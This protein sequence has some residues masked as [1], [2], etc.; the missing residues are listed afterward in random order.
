MSLLACPKLEK[1]Q[2]SIPRLVGEI[3]PLTS[4]IG[5]VFR[6]FLLSLRTY[7]RGVPRGSA[8][9]DK[10]VVNRSLKGG[11]PFRNEFE[12]MTDPGRFF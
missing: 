12:T 3:D 7:Q 8:P 5:W 11:S 6:Y 2:K 4:G 10:V 1:D 9:G